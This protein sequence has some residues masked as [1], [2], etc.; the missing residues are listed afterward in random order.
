MGM[1][2]VVERWKAPLNERGRGLG[3]G[4][5]LAEK[6]SWDEGSALWISWEE[7]PRQSPLPAN[8][9]THGEII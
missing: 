2:Q 4:E 1:G 6:A 9:M 5:E 8:E 7:L 3:R